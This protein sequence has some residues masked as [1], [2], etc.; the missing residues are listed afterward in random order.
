MMALMVWGTSSN[1]G[2]TI[3][4]SILCRHLH[5]K[6]IDVVPFKGSNLSLNSYVTD[7]G[8]EIGMGQALQAWASGIEPIADMNP[9]LLKPEGS[10]KIQYVVNGSVHKGVGKPTRKELLDL[11]CAAYDRLYDGHDVV[12]CE[13][14]GAPSEINLMEGD[15]ANIGL[16]RERRM[17]VIIVGDIERGGMFAAIYGT[18]LLIP[19]DI[20]PLIKGFI[21]NRFRGDETI[22]DTGIRRI[23]E[24]TGMKCIG[25]MPYVKD[26]IL[27][28]EDSVS[29][30]RAKTGTFED[31]RRMYDL[32]LDRLTDFAEEHL[33]FDLLD[34]IIQ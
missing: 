26:V 27:P 18:W 15:I 22:L 2:K 1:S 33:D 34:S 19:E 17:N 8:A 14:S 9:I 28:E 30:H 11:S 23:E 7:A 4:C 29:L 32:S 24:L 21:V 31:I 13:G 25:I 5:R 20:R 6:G 3:M 10:G 16:V 12:I